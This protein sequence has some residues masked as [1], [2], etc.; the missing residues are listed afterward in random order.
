MPEN[1]CQSNINNLYGN[2]FSFVIDRGT[3]KLE[4]MIQKAN[5]PGLSVPEQPQPTIFGTTI[6]VPTTSVQFEQLTVE[7]LVDSDLSNWKS[8]YSWIRD[9]TNIQDAES[10]NLA[11]KYWHHTASLILHPTLNC[12]TP[13]PVLTVKFLNIVPVRLTGLV[14]QADVADAPVLKSTCIFKYSHYEL[15][16]DAPSAL[17]QPYD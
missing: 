9:I 2:Y 3:D 8:I 17:K 1:N 14:F 4:L 12:D 11:Y 15:S 10:Y 5:L 16:P 7:F 6:P 13:N